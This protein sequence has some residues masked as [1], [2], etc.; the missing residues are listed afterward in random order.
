LATSRLTD[1]E[2]NFI[3]AQ[4]AYEQAETSINSR[5]SSLYLVQKAQPATRRSK[6]FRVPIVVGAVVLTLV[7][8]MLFI[9]LLE[10]YRRPSA[11]TPSELA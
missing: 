8:S 3:A 11:G 2:T 10:L 9:L 5:V 6:P 1:L 4:A 7:L